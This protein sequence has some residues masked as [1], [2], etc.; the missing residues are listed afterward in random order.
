M[1]K[2]TL[3]VGA[4]LLAKQERRE[5]VPRK[6]NPRGERRRWVRGGYGRGYQRDPALLDELVAYNRDDCESTAELVDWIREAFPMLRSE[7]DVEE[8]LPQSD[9]DKEKDLLEEDLLRSSL[10]VVA[11]SWVDY[12]QRT[13]PVWRQRRDWLDALPGI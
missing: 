8:A 1:V 3:L 11:S 12:H 6:R 13:R 9:E 7:E 10:P 5:A 4:A 2:R